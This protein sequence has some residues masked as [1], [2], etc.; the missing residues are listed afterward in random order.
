[1]SVTTAII[2][3]KRKNRMNKKTK[4]YPACIRVTFERVPRAFDTGI[5]MTPDDFAKLG[6]PRLGEKLR[7]IKEK[8]EKEEPRAKTIIKNLNK[9]SFVAFSDQFTAFQPGRRRRKPQIM[10]GLG[11]NGAAVGKKVALP[12]R[13]TAQRNFVNQFEKRKYPREKSTIDFP[14]LGEVAVFYGQYISKL[15]AKE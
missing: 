8:L 12:F 9:F 6:S 14:T 10:P 11:G 2:L 4:C 3:D 1:M 15:E 13:R 7:E 5:E